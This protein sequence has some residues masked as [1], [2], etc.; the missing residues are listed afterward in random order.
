MKTDDIYLKDGQWYELTNYDTCCG[1]GLMHKVKYR[2]K[3]GKI[4][5]AS[6]NMGKIKLKKNGN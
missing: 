2:I 5:R 1:C 3:N 6:W 4:E